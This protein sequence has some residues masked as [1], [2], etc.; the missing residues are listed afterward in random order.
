VFGY[1]PNGFNPT[2][3]TLHLEFPA[4]GGSAY[5]LQHTV[6]VDDGAYLRNVALT[7]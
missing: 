5:G 7:T 3:V 4:S 1:S 6:V 2:Y